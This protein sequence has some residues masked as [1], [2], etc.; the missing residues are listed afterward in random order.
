MKV[1]YNA[2]FG[3][4]LVVLA[5][6]VAWSR[7]D[8]EARVLNTSHIKT[9]QD[10]HAHD[11]PKIIP[12]EIVEELPHHLKNDSVAL[13]HANSSDSDGNGVKKL[14]MEVVYYRDRYGRI[15]AVRRRKL[16]HPGRHA[17]VFLFLM[18]FMMASQ[19]I[20]FYWKKMKPKSFRDVTLAGLWQCPLLSEYILCSGC[21]CRSG[22]SI[23]S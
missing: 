5:T 16:E 9:V 8:E 15:H 12:K 22:R 7:G 13:V 6:T 1:A 20:I 17:A 23:P 10:L 21:L 11:D 14:R 4:L 19:S 2:R 3:T 18:F